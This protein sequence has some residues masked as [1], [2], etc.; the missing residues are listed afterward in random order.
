MSARVETP[1]NSLP[2]MLFDLARRWP[3]RPMLRFWRDGAWRTESWAGFARRTA[4]V[5]A[6]LRAAL[7]IPP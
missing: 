4:A 2:S 7:P 6:G 3:D 1:W 5:A